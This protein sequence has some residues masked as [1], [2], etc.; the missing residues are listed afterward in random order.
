V[1][2]QADR[3]GAFFK[4]Q[5]ELGLPDDDHRHGAFDAGTAAS[6]DS[7]KPCG[8]THYRYP[9]GTLMVK[10]TTVC[11]ARKRKNSAGREQQK[12]ERR[13]TTT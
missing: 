5:T 13:H 3:R 7:R 6:F 10:R 4:R 11:G 9:P 8:C 1:K 12:N 2:I